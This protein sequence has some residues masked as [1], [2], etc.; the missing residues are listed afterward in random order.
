LLFNQPKPYIFGK[1]R[2]YADCWRSVLGTLENTEELW[3]LFRT[4]FPDLSRNHARIYRLLWRIEPLNG[5]AVI[6][7]TGL[8]RAT[9]YK[10]LKDL[11]RLELIKKTN[12]SPMCYFAENPITAYNRNMERI[13]RLLHKGRKI[14]TK[15]VENSSSLSEEVYLIELDGG[16]KRLISKK[17]RQTVLDEFTLR[18]MRRTIDVQLKQAEQAKLKPWML[19]NR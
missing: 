8:A 16:Q 13:S 7:E 6:K 12:F 14:V 9:T 11:V 3:S 18:E 5:E 4:F 10:I 17:N 1:R 15:L 2:N 19:T